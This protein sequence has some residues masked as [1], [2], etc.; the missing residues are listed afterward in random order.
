MTIDGLI[1]AI[2]LRSTPLPATSTHLSPEAARR[3]PRSECHF[4]RTPP[5]HTAYELAPIRCCCYFLNNDGELYGSRNRP[6]RVRE[7]PANGAEHRRAAPD[8]SDSGKRTSRGR[9]RGGAGDCDRP[10]GRSARREPREGRVEGGHHGLG[11]E[12]RR[13]R[14]ETP[15]CRG[16][17]SRDRQRGPEPPVWR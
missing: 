6:G 15:R 3:N 9:R 1:Q 11:P 10:P 13:Y 17:P 4:P 12:A 14:Q 8:A 16:L 2:A 7:R 5:I